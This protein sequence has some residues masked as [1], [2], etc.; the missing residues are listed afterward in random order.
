[1]KFM[2]QAKSRAK[3]GLIELNA[4]AESI[5]NLKTFDTIK[6]KYEKNFKF[7]NTKIQLS[8]KNYE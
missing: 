5:D 6:E 3:K 1:M 4:S 8:F 7:Y 2:K